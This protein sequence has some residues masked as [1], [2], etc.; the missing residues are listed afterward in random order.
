MS[1]LLKSTYD[2]IMAEANTIA[3][4]FPWHDKE[5]Y[6]KHVAHCFYNARQTPVLL[7]LAGARLQEYPNLQRRCFTHLGEEQGHEMLAINDL[8]AL[9]LSIKDFPEMQETA[10]LYHSQIY[11]IEHKSPIMVWGAVL[12]LEGWSALNGPFIYEQVVKAHGPKAATFRKVHK[13]ND[14]GHLA[15]AFKTI[16]ELDSKN[17]NLIVQSLEHYMYFFFEVHRKIVAKASF[18]K[19]AA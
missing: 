11:M 13:D 19:K 2:K 9:G 5:S 7:S 15:S 16:S 14:E 10:A 1:N 18:N 8:K 17:Q 4:E 12:G 3:K 6:A